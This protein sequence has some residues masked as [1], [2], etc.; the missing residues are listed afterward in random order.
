M[1]IAVLSHTLQSK[2]VEA[3]EKRGHT[4]TV[5]NPDDLYLYVSDKI[6]YDRVYAKEDRLKIKEIDAVIP[7]I[8]Q[9]LIPH[10]IAVVRH[11]SLC[12]GIYSVSSANGLRAASDKFEC[13]QILSYAKIR[14]P[15]TVIASEP[16]NPAFL[17]E[18]VGGLPA[19]AKLVRGSQGKGVMILESTLAANTALESLYKLKAEVLLQ[20][21]L[22]GESKDIRAIVVGDKVVSAMERTANKGDFRANLSKGGSGKKIDLTDEEKDMAVKAAKALELDFAGVDIMRANDTSYVIEVNGN[23]GTKIIDVTGHNHFEDLIKLI[24]QKKSGSSKDSQTI[25]EA[26]YSGYEVPKDVLHFQKLSLSKIGR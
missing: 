24:E 8:G 11:F 2:L 15:K 6:G 19:V 23:P 4:M 16:E 17:I 5:I 9:N 10:G 20:E 18:K 3:G 12:L 25:E 22:K 26:K 13:A 1:K 21:Y 7:R 14:Q